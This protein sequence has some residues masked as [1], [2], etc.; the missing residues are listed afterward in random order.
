MEIAKDD[1]EIVFDNL[2]ELVADLEDLA[3]DELI[4]CRE[5]MLERVNECLSFLNNDEYGD[6]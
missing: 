3:D 4:V 5:V 2:C 6:N 1:L